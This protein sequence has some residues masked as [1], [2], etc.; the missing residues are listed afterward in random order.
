MVVTAKDLRYS[1]GK[2]IKLAKSG[3]EITI[4]YRGKDAAKIVPLKEASSPLASTS[5]SNTADI[6]A[7]TSGMWAQRDDLNDVDSFVRDLRRGR[8]AG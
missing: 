3:K 4:S 6:I 7:K 5:S 1:A 2:I 8:H